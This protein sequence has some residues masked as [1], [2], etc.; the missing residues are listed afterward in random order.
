MSD[1]RRAS[2]AKKP[3]GPLPTIAISGSNIRQSP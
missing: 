2:A 3:L 1:F